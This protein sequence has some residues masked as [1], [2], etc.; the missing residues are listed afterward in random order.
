MAVCATFTDRLLPLTV[1]I[2][3]YLQY[4]QISGFLPISGVLVFPFNKG[5]PDYKLGLSAT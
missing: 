3:H 4:T 5:T 2:F 1:P